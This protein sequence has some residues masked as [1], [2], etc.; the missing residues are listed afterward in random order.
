MKLAVLQPAYFPN[1]QSLAQIALAD[2]VVWGDSF[3]YKKHDTI[4]RTRIKTVAGPLWLTVPV[5]SKGKRQQVVSHVKMD[6]NQ[7]WRQAHVN[8]LRVNYQNSPY[9][10]FMA[11][12]MNDLLQREW[13]SFNE[14]LFQSILFLCKKMRLTCE[15]VKSI[16]LPVVKDRSDRVLEWVK[17]CGCDSYLVKTEDEKWIDRSLIEKNSCPVFS[18][19]FTHPKYHQLF[20]GF[21][22]NMSG[23]DLLFNEGEKS[24]SIL[25]KSVQICEEK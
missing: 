1:L 13:E 23:L 12:E 10:F 17:A 11:D 6:S 8:S 18:M 21:I 9:Y 22:K 25:L 19:K 7:D 2:V 20:G 14:L 16:D 3:L 4:N 24:R 5:L 15:F